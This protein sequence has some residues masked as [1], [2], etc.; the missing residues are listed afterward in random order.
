M[1][2]EVKEVVTKTPEVNKVE[3]VKPTEVNLEEVKAQTKNDIIRELSKELGV[4]V[5]EKEGMQ[6]VKELLESQKT[7]Q[8]KLQEKLQAYE[9]EKATWQKQ[10]LNYKTKLKA[11]ELGIH[12]D[13]LEDALKLAENDPEKLVEVVKKY[14]MFKTKEGITIGVQN[15]TGTKPPTNNTEAEAYMASDPRYRKWLKTQK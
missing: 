1:A 9:E 2:E 4:N 13:H 15:P 12:N 14:P 5:F 10:E 6:Q 11:S 3:E 8:Q 7:E